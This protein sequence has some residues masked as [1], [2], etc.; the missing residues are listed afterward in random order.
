MRVERAE[1]I[2]V[3]KGAARFPVQVGPERL[4]VVFEQ[5]QIVR[6]AKR[7]NLIECRW[8]PENAYGD[9]HSC[10]RRERRVESR[11]IHVE[12]VELDVNEPKLQPILLQRMKRRGP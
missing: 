10:A 4:A 9:D 7:A 3:T 8:I 12:R 5:D 6:V 1:R 2:D 11:D